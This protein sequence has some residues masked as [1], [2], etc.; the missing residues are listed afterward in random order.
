MDVPVE[1]VVSD[2]TY[3]GPDYL[4]TLRVPILSG[5]DFTAADLNRPVAIVNRKL[6][7]ALWPGQSAVGRTITVGLSGTPLQVVGVVTDGAFN[8]VARNGEF[9]G[10][11]PEERRNY[12]FL[13]EAAHGSPGSYTFHVRYAGNPPTI[14]AALGEVDGRVPVFSVRTLQTEFED[15]T[16]PVHTFANFVG[17]SAVGGVLLAGLG[18]YAVIAFYTARRRRELGIRVALGASPGQVLGA[19][20]REGILLTTAGLIVGLALSAAAAKTFG[21]LL[22]GISPGDPKTYAEVA[23]TLAMVSLLA[24]YVPA[25]KAARVDP[26]ESLR[27]E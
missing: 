12:V 25:R 14:R 4:H 19:V 1:S 17:I 15:F 23:M 27:Q 18:L 2:G 20:L 7:N 21:S 26:M 6:A 11:A 9:A 16:L 8:A 24:C 22:Y 3:A 5:R 13:S 10:L